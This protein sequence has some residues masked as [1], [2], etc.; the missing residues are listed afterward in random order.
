MY[1]YNSWKF[2][3]F[4]IVKYGWVT[5][6]IF[7]FNDNKTD[8][9]FLYHFR[10]ASTKPYGHF[11]KHQTLDLFASFVGKIKSSRS[12]SSPCKKAVIFHSLWAIKASTKCKPSLEHVVEYQM[13]APQN[14]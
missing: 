11:F 7:D 1:C 12:I 2:I 3:I 8:F 14:S 10:D 9:T 4:I 5:F 6:G 13:F